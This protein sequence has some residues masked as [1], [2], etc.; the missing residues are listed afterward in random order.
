MKLGQLV[1]TCGVNERMVNDNEFAL[2]VEKSMKRYCKRDWG[3]TLEDDKVMNDLAV[4]NGDDRILAVYDFND[5]EKIWVITEWD[6]SVTT[7]LFPD[8]Y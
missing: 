4:K 2:F 8:E 6:H 5:E 3:D 1:F 7:I